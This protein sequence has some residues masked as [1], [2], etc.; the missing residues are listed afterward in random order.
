MDIDETFRAAI[1]SITNNKQHFPKY[2]TC[3]ATE[4]P[5]I[6]ND[7][8]EENNEEGVGESNN[9]RDDALELEEGFANALMELQ[10]DVDEMTIVG[11]DSG[12]LPPLNPIDWTPPPF[13]TRLGEQEFETVNNPDQWIELTFHP[14]FAKV[15]SIYK[16]HVP[17]TVV[18]PLS[19]D[20]NGTRRSNGLEFY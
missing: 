7:F 8:R 13:K 20:G 12:R 3:D 5:S 6:M 17:P 19:Q 15:G 18:M 16:R 2:V 1:A 14:D 10:S 9:D 11:E 4:G